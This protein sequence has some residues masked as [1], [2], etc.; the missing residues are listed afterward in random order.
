MKTKACSLPPEIVGTT[1]MS[2]RGQIVIPKIAR[3]K[4]R[5]EKGEQ[6]VLLCH[7]RKLVLVPAKEMK[8]MIA[9]MEKTLSE[10]AKTSV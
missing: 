7:D 10:F 6:I 5:L 4:M 3:E 9:H 8:E 2:E 1:V